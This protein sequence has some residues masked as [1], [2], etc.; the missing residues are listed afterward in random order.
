MK[1]VTLNN[2][3]QYLDQMQLKSDEKKYLVDK[4][5]RYPTLE[6]AM[7]ISSMWSEH[8][9]YKSSRRWFKYF[10]TNIGSEKVLLGIGEGAGLIDIGDDYIIGFKVESHNHPSAISPFEGAATGVGGIIRDI[11]S[12][13]L[14]PIGLLDS[15]RFGKLDNNNVKNLFDGVV[16][17]ISSYGNCVG[18]P[19]IGGEV[20]FA[21]EYS[22]NPLVNV[23]CVGLAK[24]DQILRS[25]ATKPG[26]IMV[27]FGAKT[28]KDGIGGV[29]FA[30]EDLDE[31]S[32]ESR[33]AVQIGDPL[34]EKILVDVISELNNK[35]L[36][37]GFQDFGGGGM[38]C[39]TSEIV[40]KN[41]F[42]AKIFL[43]KV[44]LR[45]NTMVAW[46]I[47][48]SESQERM[49]GLIEPDDFLEVGNILEKY[50]L[51][52]ARIGEVI[53]EPNYQIFWSNEQLGN[54]P[55][56]LLINNVPQ[57]EREIQIPDYIKNQENKLPVQ[58]ISLEEEIYSLM[59]EPNLVSKRWVYEQYDKTVQGQTIRSSGKGTGLIHIPNGKLLSVKLDTLPV[60]VYLDPFNGSA[61]SVTNC[62]RNI[63]ASG[64]Q[65]LA[66]VDNLNFGNPEYPDSYWQLVESIK[67]IGQA[68]SDF[69]IPIIG[70]NVS[71][72]NES[73]KKNIRKR[74]LPTPTIG[75]VGIIDNIEKI[76]PFSLEKNIGSII[77][78]IGPNPTS[79]SGSEY[80]RSIYGLQQ[81]IIPSYDF[82]SEKKSIF[83]IQ[84][85]QKENNLLLSSSSIGKG[86][87]LLTL[88]K[89]LFDD[90][91]PPQIGIDLSNYTPK[92]DL[93]LRECLFSESP[94]R[95]VI[96]V[97]YD[98]FTKVS[99][100]IISEKCQFQVI[101]KIIGEKKLKI[102]DL[103]LDLPT[104]WKKWV[105]TIPNIMNS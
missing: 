77:I 24:K 66:I 68:S 63:V 21:Y 8:I 48:I 6:E 92:T 87:L 85:L 26:L 19:N 22:E 25:L 15:I 12:H 5:G 54:I 98:A 84:K 103:N 70:G 60:H 11:I 91:I 83:T 37:K 33:S 82:E 100:M 17:G 102:N 20:E 64:A 81:G 93:N 101:G 79:L 49:L 71:L 69:E 47:I 3:P 95:F 65:P 94:S 44:P 32:D 50:E 74:I 28:G 45:D 39:A 40:A 23:M 30:S 46:E 78:V 29:T 51:A 96:Q 99:D 62:L 36:L 27:M 88:L 34:K 31:K 55:I 89:M 35:K 53:S 90:Y 86:G 76:T 16:R 72:Y 104:L 61:N 2:E 52:Y 80:L 1:T 67:G 97:N 56:E 7:C 42:G 75:I 14:H 4:L 59:S 9:S 58:F 38:I 18:V 73:S 13:G 10:N 105:C 57:P 43:D 41:G